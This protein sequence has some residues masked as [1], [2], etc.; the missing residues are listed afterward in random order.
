MSFWDIILETN[1]FNFVILLI[2]LAILYHILHVPKIVENL[3]DSIISSIENAKFEQADAVNRLK[4]AQNKYA[5]LGQEIKVREEEAKQKSNAIK[6][7]ILQ[8][9]DS[10]IDAINKKIGDA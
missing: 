6:S 3:K 10:R 1:T 5:K 8:D 2:I 7:Q 9:A 4:D